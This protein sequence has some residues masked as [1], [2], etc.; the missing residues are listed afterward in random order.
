MFRIILILIIAA[1]TSAGISA[2]VISGPWHGS[3]DLGRMQ[4]NL[5]FRFDCDSTGRTIVTLD[6]PD[7]GAKGLPV[8]AD[9]ISEDSIAISSPAL[10]MTYR[11]HR[12]AEK[13]S[14]TFS[15]AGQHF[16]LVLSAGEV[17]RHRPQT[18]QPTYPYA[19]QEVTFVNPDDGVTLAGTLTRPM[20]MPSTASRPV[21]VVL[22][23]T[24]SGLQ[25]RDEEIMD[26]KPF[27]V[28]ADHLARNGIASLRYDDRGFGASDGDA[29]QATTATFSRDAAAGL[30][31][32]RS[33]A[34]FG[35]IGVLGHSEGGTIAL[36]LGAS[37]G[38]DFVI[39]M[40]GAAIRGDSILAGQNKALLLLSGIP[41]HI[42]EA[43]ASALTDIYA[44]RIKYPEAECTAATDGLPQQLADNLAHIASMP[45]GAWLT[46]FIAYDPTEAITNINCP[47]MAIN[48][49]LDCQVLATD[50]LPALRRNLPDT[51][52]N[53]IKEYPGLNHLM[54]HCTTGAVTE[55]G[56][57][58]ETISPEVL[59]DITAWIKSLPRH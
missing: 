44:H 17:P 36:M 30:A 41:D 56:T 20:L 16:N 1:M 13:I 32:L 7:Q 25:N 8:T 37:G 34:Q 40:A 27:A 45:L 18:P 50:N 35:S 3:L 29:S 22:M 59:T 6:S 10:G 4:L 57:I 19:P 39:S 15:Q 23:V 14:G 51:P 47:V 11:A 33:L 5:V 46:H 38:A 26:H 52:G 54:Q 2:N 55:Y 43:Y 28:I 42:A 58:E 21:P 12:S 49:S 48:G 24:G 31:Y 9:F 53:L